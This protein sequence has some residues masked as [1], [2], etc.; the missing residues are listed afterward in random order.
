GWGEPFLHPRLFDFVALARQAGCAVSSTSCGLLMDQEIGRQVV[1]SGMDVLAFSLAGTDEASNAIRRRAPF[2]RV[3][4]NMRLMAGVKKAM[5]AAHPRLHCAYIL[6]ADRMEAVLALPDLIMKLGL[7]AAVV[8]TL[9]YLAVPGQE[10]LA[11][12]P[13]EADKIA[14]ARDLLEKA[15]AR[16][17]RLGLGFHYGLP[18]PEPWGTCREQVD[19]SLYVDGD[20]ALSPCIYVNVPVEGTG[21]HRLVFGNVNEVDGFVCWQGERFAAFRKALATGRPEPPCVHCAKR[22]E[23]MSGSTI[24]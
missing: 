14:K 10:F 6:L 18:N 15:A 12:A 7:Q 5:N 16:A 24:D 13:H 21:A 9:D 2:A 22:F 11:F 1:A 8:S 20:G 23:K 19:R 17:A 4:E 3:C